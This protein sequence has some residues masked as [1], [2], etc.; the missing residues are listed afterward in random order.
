MRTFKNLLWA[1]LPIFALTFAVGCEDPQSGVDQPNV[2]K[3]SVIKLDK[4]TV[5]VGV[6]GGTTLIEYTIENAHAGE[7]SLQRL[8]SHGL[9][10]LT[11]VSQV[12]LASM[13]M[14]TPV[15]RSVSAW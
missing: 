8:L 15:L 14:L 11:M 5:N 3:D 6:A 13:L 12:L 10:T 4:T 1:I 7:R 9:I 2:V